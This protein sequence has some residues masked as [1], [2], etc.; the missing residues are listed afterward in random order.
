MAGKNHPHDKD[1]PKKTLKKH[2]TKEDKALCETHGIV[3]AVED[4]NSAIEGHKHD[5]A[6]RLSHGGLKCYCA[7]LGCLSNDMQSTCTVYQDAEGWP[8]KQKE[9]CEWF[10]EWYMYNN[11]IGQL[12]AGDHVT[13]H[14]VKRK[15]RGFGNASKLEVLTLLQL[16]Q[17]HKNI[18]LKFHEEPDDFFKWLI[19]FR[20]SLSSCIYLGTHLL[21]PTRVLAQRSRL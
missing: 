3:P 6:K 8:E 9:G 4:H 11:I 18:H 19:E 5:P 15:G 16:K 20:L 10:H 12:K 21:F 1:D 17:H 14:A 13:F 7:R 2:W